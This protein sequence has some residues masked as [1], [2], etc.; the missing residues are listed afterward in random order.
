MGISR[1]CAIQFHCGV[2]PVWLRQ[3]IALIR[4]YTYKHIRAYMYV[5][6]YTH[7]HMY[8]CTHVYTHAHTEHVH[9]HIHI[10]IRIITCTMHRRRHI[11]VR[12][13][14]HIHLNMIR[15][16]SAIQSHWRTA[17]PR[18]LVAANEALLVFF[19]VG[20]PSARNLSVKVKTHVAKR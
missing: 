1:R 2:Y 11:H 19:A 20:A 7:V 5:Y 15:L 8:I 14:I 12:I 17:K 4:M 10:H 18:K 9:V 3:T 16:R 6:M 13:R